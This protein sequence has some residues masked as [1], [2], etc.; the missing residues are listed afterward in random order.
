MVRVLLSFL[1]LLVLQAPL[2]AE[3]PDFSGVSASEEFLPVEQA[4]RLES[5]AEGANGLRLAWT[6]APGYALYRDRIATGV[7]SPAGVT[8]APLAFQGA[9]VFKNDP[10]FGR[11]AVFHDAARA[12]LTL[13]NVPAGAAGKPV[14][15]W[16]RYQGCADAGLCYPPQTVKLT[17]DKP[18]AASAG[19]V[20]AAVAAPSV[21]AASGPVVTESK[22]PLP[23]AARGLEDAGGIAGFLGHA[24]LPLILLTFFV[25]GLGLTFT[26]C[27]FPMMPILSGLIAGDD[28]KEM[29]TAR[30]FRLSLAYV[31]GMATTYAIVGMLV[32][33]FGAR[34]NVQLWLQTPVVLIGFAFVFVLLAFSMFGFYELQLPSFLRDQ[35]HN[36][37]N[38]QKGG[39]LAGVFIMG[40][41][42]ALVVSPC[43][44][45]PL[46]GTLVYISTTGD[47]VLGG[48]ALLALGLGM[49]APL[50]LIGTSGGKL[51]PRAGNW[52]LV[53]KAIF[54][55]SL[56][57]VAIWLVARVV[58]GEVTLVLWGLLLGISG[59]YMGALEAAAM[60]WHRLWKGLGLV[61]L[62]YAAFL[63]AGAATGQDDPLHPLGS[64][65][66]AAV[67]PNATL[68]Q[69]VVF[70]R[71]STE[72]QLRAAL[73]AARDAGKPAVVDFYADWCAACQVMERT[74][75]R[76]PGVINSL[77]GQV[78]VQ[79]DLSDNT[80]E[81]RRLLETFHLYGPPAMLFFD[82]KGDEEKDMRVQSEISAEHLRAR[83]GA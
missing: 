37:S 57:A 77:A 18:Q 50:V 69:H 3:V 31:L 19:P 33:Y 62:L 8:L 73:G 17:F 4:F 7:D 13:A 63:F 48:L 78:R 12:L 61:C 66:H 30:A 81:Q 51:L 29:G 54:G 76:D 53:V 5:V 55:V 60:G 65:A 83:L 34:F 58:P 2:R 71:V 36:L 24:S 41:L 39:R 67:A 80:D 6:V 11:V 23:S 14:A 75:F 59:I 10:S 49:G 16:V 1:F 64:F 79:M 52:M 35:L 21:T 32:G 44:S 47:A 68:P 38:K 72:Q 46:A 15:V 40:I 20:T 26:P 74:T 22:E 70:Q 25:L 42:S 56:L 9:A 28:S 82:A 27:V 43:V 45:A